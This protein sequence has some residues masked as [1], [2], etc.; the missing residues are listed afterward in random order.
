[1]SAVAFAAEH[2]GADDVLVL[3]VRSVHSG[4]ISA[5]W[6]AWHETRL[7]L[8]DQRLTAETGG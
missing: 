4:I 2:A 6:R 3:T 8:D 7:I 5:S 1:M